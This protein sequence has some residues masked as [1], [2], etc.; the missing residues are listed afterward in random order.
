MRRLEQATADPATLSQE[1]IVENLDPLEA[2]RLSKV[3]NI[4]IAVW[5][6]PKLDGG[7]T[8]LMETCRHTLT[9]A[10]QQ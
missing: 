10:K 2:K 6:P 3:R 4:G 8:W 1:T 9:R 5:N 7:G